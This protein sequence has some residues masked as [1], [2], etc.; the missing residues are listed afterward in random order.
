LECAAQAGL[1]IGEAGQGRPSFQGAVAACVT[2]AVMGV[3]PV[4]SINGRP[5]D[6]DHPALQTLIAL[7]RTAP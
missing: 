1:S 3:V 7:E 2:N 6:V 5:L 4:A